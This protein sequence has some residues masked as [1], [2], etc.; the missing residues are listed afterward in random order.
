[1]KIIPEYNILGPIKIG[2]RKLYYEH[3]NLTP[4]PV[5]IIDI[6]TNVYSTTIYEFRRDDIPTATN[7][8]TIYKHRFKNI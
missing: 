8:Y 5:T 2:D 7:N 4:I 6:I 3:P 1:M